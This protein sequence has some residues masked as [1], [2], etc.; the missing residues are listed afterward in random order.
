MVS[1]NAGDPTSI[2]PLV[3]IP[4]SAG[5]GVTVSHCLDGTRHAL[6]MSTSGSAKRRATSVMEKPAKRTRVSRACDQCRIAREKCNGTQPTC[7]T[8]SSSKRSCTYTAN[9]KKRGIQ[10]GYIRALE[11]ALAYL[12]QHDPE[13]ES[14]VNDKLAQGG[15]SSLLLS[16]ESKDSIKLHK[17]WRKTRFHTDVDKLLSGGEPSR[18]NQ[19]EPLLP[20]TD[21]EDSDTED[22]VPKATAGTFASVSEVRH[23]DALSQ[24]SGQWPVTPQYPISGETLVSMPLD[25]WRLLE[26]YFIYTQSWFPIC[27]KENILKLSY[28]YPVEGIALSIELP[29]SGLHAELWSILAVASALDNLG[30]DSDPV[31]SHERS[32]EPPSQIYATARSMIPKERGQFDLGHVKAALNLAILDIRRSSMEAAWL[33]V[34]YACRILE[35][36]GSSVLRA[37]PRHKHVFHGCYLLDCMLAIHLNLS[38]YFSLSKIR[39]HGKVDEDGLDEWQPWNAGFDVYAGQQPRAP[40]LSLSSFNAISDVLAL[41]HDFDV[42]ETAHRRSQLLKFWEISLPPKLAFVCVANAPGPLNPPAIL[43][44]LTYFCAAFALTSSQ[45]WVTRLLKLLERAQ[46][47]IGWKRLPPVLRCLLEYIKRQHSVRPLSTEVHS[48]L[49]KVLAVVNAAWPSD[50]ARPQMQ[51]SC[52][53]AVS[54]L[55]TSGQTAVPPSDFQPIDQINLEDDAFV[56]LAPLNPAPPEAYSVVP[57]AEQFNPQQPNS[58]PAP[59]TPVY[60]NIPSDLESFFD[61]L[62]SLDTVNN[63]DN[64][65]QFL[66]NLGFAPDASMADLFSDYLPMQSSAFL[67][68]QNT[69]AVNLDHYGFFEGT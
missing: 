55:H 38:P 17:R 48:R 44:R 13:N 59:L 54:Q 19:S 40:S 22:L 1:H 57:Q 69:D 68:Q 7:S 51:A 14:L 41:L 31:S 65:P 45:I 2:E 27:S 46:D 61:D 12:F 62:A 9:V 53:P 24:P 21:D 29:D 64:Q 3:V 35:T 37:N 42:E 25:S 5:H 6:P 26:I 58:V 8:C 11:L 10:P 52:T 36:M 56:V 34:G 32:A 23:Q 66:Q 28:A 63:P 67:S 18:Q 15:T 20:E 47:E 39:Q 50:A 4:D 16:R 43:L 60:P 30:S 49:M 33:L